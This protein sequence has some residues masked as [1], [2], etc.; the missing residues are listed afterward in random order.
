MER[1]GT[2]VIFV[3]EFLSTDAL[4]VDINLLRANQLNTLTRI[5]AL[6]LSL[7]V[8]F[9]RGCPTGAHAR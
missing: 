2:A 6:I 9:C 1:K 4:P 8:I 7:R 5:T 3:K